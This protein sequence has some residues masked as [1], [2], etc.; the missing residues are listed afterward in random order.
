[1]IKRGYG[2]VEDQENM[3]SNAAT[4]GTIIEMFINIGI[5]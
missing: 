2:R 3:L 4:F 1:M 5:L